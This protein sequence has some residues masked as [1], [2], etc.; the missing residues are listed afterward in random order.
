MPG[1][2]AGFEVTNRMRKAFGMIAATLALTLIASVAL[3][4]ALPPQANSRAVDVTQN[5]PSGAGVSGHPSAEV[6]GVPPGPPT[7]L[8]DTAPY[9]PPEWV[10][11]S[12]GPPTWVTTP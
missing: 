3:A 2:L 12:G 10:N 1:R 7:W 9:G 6:N 4:V 5:T 11:T 8:N